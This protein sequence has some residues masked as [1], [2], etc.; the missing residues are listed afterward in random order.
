MATRRR[1][2]KQHWLR[3]WTTSS[4][5]FAARALSAAR[6][7]ARRWYRRI[8][9]THPAVLI[10]APRREAWQLHR[11][12]RRTARTYARALG[13]ELP[14]GLAII[15]QRFVFDGHQV[16]GLLQAYE[17]NGRRRYVIQLALSINGREVSN[18]ELVASLRH[19]LAGA[20]IDAIGKP[21]LSVVLD[22]EGAA[23]VRSGGSIVELR[24]RLSVASNGH[25]PDPFALSRVTDFP[26]GEAS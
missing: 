2:R 1:S 19:Q 25:D 9:G 24:P 3:R 16:N 5:A 11:L 4:R 12:V 8:R 22:L 21:V 15:A 7:K 14:E 13:T 17:R 6:Q 10:D 26:G 20:L 23:P 18:D